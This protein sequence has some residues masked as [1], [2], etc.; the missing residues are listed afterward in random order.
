MWVS[1]ENQALDIFTNTLL[2]A[3]GTAPKTINIIP[4][5]SS[6][7]VCAKNDPDER[8]ARI[9]IVEN[10]NENASS[11]TASSKSNVL[12][13][14]GKPFASS[15]KLN[16]EMCASGQKLAALNGI[17][18]ASKIMERSVICST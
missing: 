1:G 7:D 6:V 8:I 9:S 4:L 11:N 3:L 17:T 13:S 15:R 2:N 12:F 5:V 10:G 14:L 18:I 16:A